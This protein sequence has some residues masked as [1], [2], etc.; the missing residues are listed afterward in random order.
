MIFRRRAVLTGV[1]CS[2][3]VAFERIT[4]I[5]ETRKKD[6]AAGRDVQIPNLTARRLVDFSSNALG[7]VT[8]DDYIG[9]YHTCGFTEDQSLWSTYVR[10]AYHNP[11][12]MD[13]L[14]EQYHQ[15]LNKTPRLNKTP[16]FLR[17]NFQI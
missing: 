13:S 10:D 12:T 2:A 7:K 9:S 4:D 3:M 17:K 8:T 15:L 1:V 14:P 11:P 16:P 6:V 5:I